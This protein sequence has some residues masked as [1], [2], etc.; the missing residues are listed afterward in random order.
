MDDPTTTESQDASAE[1]RG[2]LMLL[3]VLQT[4]G[5]TRTNDYEP[6]PKWRNAALRPS[7]QDAITLLLRTQIAAKSLPR[8]ANEHPWLPIYDSNRPQPDNI[9]KSDSVM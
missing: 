5:P 7:C 3:S 2:S 4:Y 6:L 1:D 9:S 8:K